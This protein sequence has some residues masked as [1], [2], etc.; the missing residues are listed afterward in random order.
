MNSYSFHLTWTFSLI[1][2][3]KVIGI[4]IFNIKRSVQKGQREIIKNKL[5]TKYNLTSFKLMTQTFHWNTTWIHTNIPLTVIKL[6]SCNF[7]CCETLFT[8]H[9]TTSILSVPED[10]SDCPVALNMLIRKTWKIANH[11]RH[12]DH[13]TGRKANQTQCL[14]WN[15]KRPAN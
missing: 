8:R 7:F 12:I 15:R 4:H 1:C 13:Y 5:L 14:A 11:T 9:L 3:F 2:S 10:S 6:N